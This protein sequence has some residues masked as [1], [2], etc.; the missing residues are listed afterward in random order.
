LKN[1]FIV[2]AVIETGVGVAL[3]TF[4]SEAVS[5]LLGAPL[6]SPVSVILGRICGAAL[7]TIGV[8]NWFAQYDWQSRAA[9]GL[10]IGMAVY[11]LAAAAILG[12]AAMQLFSA[13]L[14]LWPVVILH[15]ALFVWCISGIAEGKQ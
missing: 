3:L 9:R 7:T 15:A 11:N 5:M 2:T 6:E 4:P 14:A 12:L 13:G 1:L 8:A 10:I